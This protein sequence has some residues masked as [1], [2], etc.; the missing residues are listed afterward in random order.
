MRTASWFFQL[1]FL[2]AS[3]STLPTIKALLV[4]QRGQQPQAESFDKMKGVTST[5]ASVAQRQRQQQAV[6]SVSR[7]PEEDGTTTSAP[8][9]TPTS[10]P[11]SFV[12]VVTPVAS[13]VV[14]AVPVASPVTVAPSVLSLSVQQTNEDDAKTNA[15]TV[16]PSS[17]TA[18][19]S[20]HH[21]IV[22][23]NF[24]VSSTSQSIT[25][26]SVNPADLQTVFQVFVET[27]I[28]NNWARRL[29]K[30]LGEQ[31][32]QQGKNSLRGHYTH[33]IPRQQQQPQHPSTNLNKNRM[34]RFRHRRRLQVTLL[35]DSI[36]MQPHLIASNGCT[37][38]VSTGSSDQHNHCH[39]AHGRF[40]VLATA[41]ETPTDVCTKLRG[42]INTLM[43]DDQYLDDLVTTNAANSNSNNMKLR[44][45]AMEFCMPLDDFVP[46]TSSSS[47][48]PVA[49]SASASGGI[50]RAPSV[51]SPSNSGTSPSSISNV[52]NDSSN[53]TNNGSGTNVFERD[54]NDTTTTAPAAA[55][56]TRIPTTRIPTTPVPSGTEYQDSWLALLNGVKEE[57][58]DAE[59]TAAEVLENITNSNNLTSPR[60]STNDTKDAYEQEQH[61]FSVKL[62]QVV[63]LVLIVLGGLCVGVCC[64]Y[65]ADAAWIIYRWETLT[66]ANGAYLHDGRYYYDE[67]HKFS[68]PYDDDLPQEAEPLGGII[69]SDESSGA[70]FDLF[71]S[72]GSEEEEE[73]DGLS[74][75]EGEDDDEDDGWGDAEDDYDPDEDVE[76]SGMMYVDTSEQE[77]VFDEDD[78]DPET[79]RETYDEK[80]D[81]FD[82]EGEANGS[83]SPAAKPKKTKQKKTTG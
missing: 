80:Q 81:I 77:D 64:C 37:V 48:A 7:P 49:S 19:T 53:S 82:D 58:A 65:W 46:P 23:V 55:P 12:P 39:A 6:V 4:V 75:F 25:N 9:S 47:A 16:A 1:L 66:A 17:S 76:E 63:F 32:P 28:Q 60:P 79:Y 11:S 68:R 5:S 38:S 78:N 54:N 8:T 35:P 56:S 29:R 57:A 27:L 31:Q 73:E 74:E 15:T 50:T 3:A 26:H 36:M 59:E 24:I 14:A 70:Q 18:A 83:S 42:S 61:E 41:D 40:E 2:L 43:E 30:L 20:G 44:P 45:G 13:P 62:N 71:H 67:R 72:E 33:E 51:A 10:M 22:G 52:S 69:E 34:T 21:L